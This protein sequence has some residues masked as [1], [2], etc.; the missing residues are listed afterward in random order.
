MQ[1]HRYKKL[2]HVCRI[3]FGRLLSFKDEN[4]DEQVEC[5]DCGVVKKGGHKSLCVCGSKLNSG[6]VA[7]FR[8]IPNPDIRPEVPAQIVVAFEETN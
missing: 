7:G 1:A 2:D 8:C 4:G 6:K 5:A 3:C